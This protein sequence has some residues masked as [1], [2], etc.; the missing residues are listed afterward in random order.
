MIYKFSEKAKEALK[1]YVYVLSD[2]DTKIPFYIGK[3]NGDRVFNHFREQGEGEKIEKLRELTMLG[4]EP[5]IDILAYGLT[6][7]VAKV[8]EMAAIGLIGLDN[9]TNRKQGDGAKEHG[10][11]SV[12]KFNLLHS[13]EEIGIDEFKENAV[14]LK[15]NKTYTPDMSAFELY[16][17]ARGYWR[18]DKEKRNK[19]K[20][21]MPVYDG[22]ILEV[23]N[24]VQWFEAKTT[25]RS[26]SQDDIAKGRS[27]FVGQIAPDNI[28]ARYVGRSVRSLVKDAQNPIRYIISKQI[29]D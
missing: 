5:C 8:V 14:L 10:R 17:A 28:R 16:E 21:A 13:A 18:M 12:D 27:E 29:S 20:Y 26:I 24:I 6:D 22:V 3:G 25:L 7:E 4:K 1:Y 9:L 2:P 15:L 11:I 19:V 23:Y